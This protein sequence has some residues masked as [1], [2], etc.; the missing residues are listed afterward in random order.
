MDLLNIICFADLVIKTRNKLLYVPI[1]LYKVDLSLN[2][3][4]SDIPFSIFVKRP[5]GEIK[6]LNFNIKSCFFLDFFIR[7]M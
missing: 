2:C 4:V 3:F 1:S 7:M 6:V 5:S